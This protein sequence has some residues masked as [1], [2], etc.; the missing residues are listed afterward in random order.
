MQGAQCLG[1]GV[2]AGA[3]R[4]T[5]LAA[6]SRT[7]RLDSPT[8]PRFGVSGIGLRAVGFRVEGSSLRVRADKARRCDGAG[9]SQA[10]R[11]GLSFGGS[12]ALR[13]N[14]LE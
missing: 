14:I 13:K 7:P 12:Q 9:I 3:W 10:R 4:C 11:K 8:V 2:R 6:V 5:K 1:L